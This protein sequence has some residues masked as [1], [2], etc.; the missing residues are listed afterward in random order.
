MK[1]N[2]LLNASMS[3]ATAL[4]LFAL[5]AC[6]K[7]DIP[8]T[9]T[10]LITKAN[11]KMVKVEQKDAA[12]NWVDITNTFDACELDNNLIFKSNLTY[13]SNEGATKCD[14]VDPQIIEVGTWKFENNETKLSYT[15]NGSTVADLVDIVGITAESFV[16]TKIFSES[17]S[18]YN[19]RIS[20]NH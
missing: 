11:W 8:L 7:D 4:F 13:E 6:Q 10:Q 1:K 2:V 3:F 16:V 15:E 17:G 18:N 14:D 12:G 5:P 9:K 20:Y 19:Y